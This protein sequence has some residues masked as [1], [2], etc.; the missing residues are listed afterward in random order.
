M[1]GG[2]TKFFVSVALVGLFGL[3]QAWGQSS[4]GALRGEVVDSE[5]AALPGVQVTVTSPALIQPRSV[6]SGP[7]GEFNVPALPVGMYA[8]EATLA[9]FAPAKQENIRVLLGGTAQV[10]LTM[11]LE[12]MAVTT[13]VIGEAVPVIDPSDTSTGGRVTYEELLKVPTAR[14][15]WAVLALVPGIQSDRVNVGGS[16]SGQQSNYVGKGERGANS[17]WSIDGVTITDAGA[18]GSSP[19]YYDFGAI[20]E[21]QV[22]TG[23]NDVSQLSGGIGINIVTKRGSNAFHGSG[24]VFFTNDTLQ[25]ENLSDELQAAFPTYRSNT[26]DQIL[27]FGGD[28]GGPIV[29]DRFWFWGSANRNKI[30]QV[31]NTGISDATELLNYAGKLSGQLTDTNEVNGFYHF[32]DK[33]KEGRTTLPLRDQDS[34]WNQGGGTPVYKLEDQQ[35]F[36]SDALLAGKFAYVGGGF[37]L[38]PQG[39]SEEGGPAIQGLQDLDTGYFTRNFYHYETDRPQTMFH[40]DGSYFKSFGSSDHDFKFGFSYRHTPVE[41]R[42]FWDE[43]G[44]VVNNWLVGVNPDGLSNTVFE[45]AANY[46][47]KYVGNT[48]SLYASDTISAGNLTI[49]LGVRFDRQTTKNDESG[50]DANVIAPDLMPELIVPADEENIAEYNLLSPRVGL[51]YQLGDKTLLKLN[52]ALYADQIAPSIATLLNPVGSQYIYTYFDDRDGNLQASRSEFLSG[53]PYCGG[54]CFYGSGIDPDQPNLLVSLNQIDAD[55]GVPKTHEAVLGLTQQVGR[56]AS[57]GVNLTYRRRFNTQWDLPL[58]EDASGAVRPVTFADWTARSVQNFPGNANGDFNGDFVLD[59]YSVQGFA[60]NSGTSFVGGSLRTNRPG[61]HEQFL[62]AELLFQKRFSDR[63]SFAANLA[64]NDWTEHFEVGGEGDFPNPNRTVGVPHEDGGDVAPAAGGASGPKGQV[65]FNAKWQSNIRGSY[66]I[67]TIDV[68]FGGSVTL[69]Q[70]YPSPFL[71]RVSTPSAGSSGITD[72]LIGNLTD[73]RMENV[74]T[75][76]LR[77]GK[78]FNFTDSVGLELSA[79]LFNALNNGVLLQHLR[80]DGT[81][82]FLQPTEVLSPRL[83]RFSARLKF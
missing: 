56:D 36:G 41:S 6:V 76:D 78:E 30:E 1:R 60:L 81:S 29:K 19:T 33:T 38:F 45:I 14:D 8:V 51:G 55:L 3:T 11:R 46:F 52:Y 10:K 73:V 67:P 47:V 70:G 48:I 83:L 68:D 20:E 49:D 23:G 40:L 44:Y 79:D 24:R 53:Q 72:L 65:F 63:W 21:V 58:I 75:A 13:E 5:G 66:T 34:S 37:H 16:E 18:I 15:P 35:I 71:R 28:V 27:E 25:G 43:G 57:V 61:F 22:N 39:G 77:L 17:V 31:L 42:S 82:S 62:G 32:G 64:L 12:S 9:S 26:T 59:P 74:I 54:F 7:N 80:R 4:R 50:R 69:R 2:W